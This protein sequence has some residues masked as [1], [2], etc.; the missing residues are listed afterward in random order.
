M[1]WVVVITAT[2]R[3]IEEAESFARSHIKT[4]SVVM[5][6]GQTTR[7][8][9]QYR[10]VVIQGVKSTGDNYNAQQEAED[11]RATGIAQGW[12]HDRRLT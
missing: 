4:D 9:I 5:F 10:V 8:N 12:L 1:Q 3:P 11:K 2:L 7:R 6:R